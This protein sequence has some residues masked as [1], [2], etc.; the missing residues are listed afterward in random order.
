M[1][2]FRFKDEDIINSKIVAFPSYTVELNGD[3]VTGSIY[4]E[5]KFLNDSLTL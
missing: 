1:S 2:F 5:K 4:L 3:A